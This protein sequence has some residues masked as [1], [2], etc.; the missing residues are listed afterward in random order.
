MPS[1]QPVNNDTPL[2]RRAWLRTFNLES[3]MLFTL[4]SA[5]AS[6]AF[7]IGIFL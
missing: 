4:L 1:H 6:A 5:T 7:A 2:S 3:W